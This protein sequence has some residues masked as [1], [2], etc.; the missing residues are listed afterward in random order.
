MTRREA[1]IIGAYT[2]IVVGTFDDIH[3]YVEESLGRPVWTHEFA[4]ESLQQE[5][6]E[7]SKSD[8]LSITITD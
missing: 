3:R 7:K 5:I 2:G 8:F 1:A 4:N 6:K